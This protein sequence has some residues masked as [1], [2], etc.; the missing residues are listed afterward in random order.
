M[1][2][3][4]HTG[5]DWETFRRRA[6]TAVRRASLQFARGSCAVAESRGRSSRPSRSV[7]GRRGRARRVTGSQAGW[8]CRPDACRISGR[9]ETDRRCG[10]TISRLSL[11]RAWPSRSPP[12]RGGADS[13]HRPPSVTAQVSSVATWS[14]I[15]R[16][17][18]TNW[19][20]S[21]TSWLPPIPHPLNPIGHRLVHLVTAQSLQNTER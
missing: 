17:L 19:S 6:N 11:S 4:T 12:R 16:Q 8:R 7:T 13:A 15:G 10:S 2:T 20:P 1:S 5:Q 18:V 9:M 3:H 21:V 14:P